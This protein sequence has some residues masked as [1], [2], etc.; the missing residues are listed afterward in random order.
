M[1]TVRKEI[2]IGLVGYGFIGKVHTMG[3][4]TLP[5]YYENAPY[6]VKLSGVASR[7]EDNRNRALF[8]AGY[9]FASE[10]YL[11]LMERNDI[12]VI[13]CCTPNKLHKPVALAAMKAG[14]HIYCEKPLARNVAEALEMARLAKETGVKSKLAF[15]YRFVPA[16]MRAKQLIEEGALGEVF[17][18][19]AAYLHSGYIDPDRPMSWR[20]L[21]EESGGGALFDLGSHILDLMRFL[22]GDYEEVQANLETFIKERPAAGNP[23]QKLK[24]D[25]DDLVIMQVRMKNNSLGTIEASR[26]ATGTNDELRFEI[27][28]NRGAIT[29]DLMEPNWLKFYDATEPGKPIGGRRGFKKIET[30]QRYPEEPVFPGPKFA[31]GW[32][33]YHIAS[34]H[35]L[36]ASLVE[37]RA[38]LGATFE[39]G[40]RIQEVMAAAEKS[41]ETGSWIKVEKNIL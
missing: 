18:F 11:E 23:S 38:P 3:Y 32:I 29:F 22:L 41:A 14:K 37:D 21:K 1:S 17:N 10:D 33:R 15:H 36:L 20:L 30:V 31:I 26:V 13:D 35:D 27:H 40:L 6:K 34:Q 28:G 24:V 2:G 8:Q 4:L 19:R 12:D 16:V 7:S 39:D 9:N 5:F 25:V